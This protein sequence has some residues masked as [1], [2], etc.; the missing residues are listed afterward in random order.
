MCVLC[1]ESLCDPI[2]IEREKEKYHISQSLGISVVIIEALDLLLKRLSLSLSC[3]IYGNIKI[4][5]EREVS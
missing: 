2:E 3:I 5:T 1:N 4:L